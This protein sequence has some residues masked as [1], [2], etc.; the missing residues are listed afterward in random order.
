MANALWTANVRHADKY[1]LYMG[2]AIE[3]HD[4][5]IGVRCSNGTEAPAAKRAYCSLEL[6]NKPS[7]YLELRH[8]ERLGRLR[9]DRVL[10][11]VTRS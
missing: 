2:S 10:G 3:L 8:Y 5:D 7:G 6:Y 4:I 9:V 1:A 11:K